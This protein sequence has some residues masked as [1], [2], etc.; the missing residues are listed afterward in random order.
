MKMLLFE[1]KKYVL[2]PSVIVF[3]A[4]FAIVNFV[5]FF[6]IYYYFGGGRYSV[7]GT[8]N[9]SA[10][11]DV[12]Y[13][14]YGGSITQEKING[15]IAEYYEAQQKL[16]QRGIGETYYDDCYTGYPYGDVGLF[17]DMLIPAYEYAILYANTANEVSE[18][19]KENVAFFTDVNE[20]ET[21]K[22]TLI[23]ETFN[24]RYVDYCVNSDGWTTFFDYKFSTILV[25]LMLVLAL[26]SVFS[27][28]RAGGFD[29]LIVSSGKRKAAVRSKLI[30][31]AVY[32]FTLTLVFF[33][34]DVFYVAV[35]HGLDCFSAPVY[36]IEA[37]KYCPFDITLFGALLLTFFGRCSA[38]LLFAAIT[39][40]VSSFGKNTAVSLGVSVFGGGILIFLSDILPAPI[41]PLALSYMSKA[42][43]EFSVVSIFGQPVFTTVSA[44]VFTLL[45]TAVLAALTARRALK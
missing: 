7:S 9:I 17:R 1:L 34:L 26:S 21:K 45:T 11:Y 25:M 44:F 28:E 13:A 16:D 14:K 39:A 6:E 42:Y 33:A 20:F 18:L 24:G 3:L 22:N 43:S 15:I 32:A 27:G 2:K 4:L 36:A 8:D 38:M 12:L 37:Y 31:A 30:M 40:F 5:K 23:S 35:F 10:G 19:A 41:N 29:K